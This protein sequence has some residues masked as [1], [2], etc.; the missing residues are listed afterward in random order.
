[1][2]RITHLTKRFG[3][4][5][6]VDDVSFSVQTG[7]ALALWGSNGAG[8]TTIIRCILDLL[9]YRGDIELAQLN[10]RKHGKRARQ[11]IGY[12][13]QELAF[14]DDMRVSETLHFYTRLRGVERSRPATVL[15]EVG[16][17][18]HGVK[19]VRE[20][21]G[22]M[23]QR[24]ALALALLSDPSLLLLDE[25]TSNLDIAAQSSFAHL[26]REQKL[27]GKSILFASHRLEEVEL[28]ADRVMVL[29]NGR[30]KLTCRADEFTERMGL[31]CVLQVF[32]QTDQL[33]AAVSSLAESGYPAQ[34]N[35]RSLYVEVP[36]NAKAGIFTVLAGNDIPV[37]NFEVTSDDR[38]SIAA[39]H[40]REGG[41]S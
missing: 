3:R 30:E 33:D 9:W 40:P 31:R 15:K 12:V 29:E 23:K 27:K 36:A 4:F 24:L 38:R 22:G 32:V 39:M 21:S 25:P 13:P 18:E 8:K 41:A 7:E 11:L 17:A 10:V 19:R 14:H 35:G 37:R 16:L 26:L 6:A 2:I 5:R 34:R 20:L 28:V 1:M